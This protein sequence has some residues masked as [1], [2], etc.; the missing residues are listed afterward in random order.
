MMR[1][2]FFSLINHGQDLKLYVCSH[3][4]DE[5]CAESMLTLRMMEKDLLDEKLFKFKPFTMIYNSL[6]MSAAKGLS[7]SESALQITTFSFN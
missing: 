6:A 4:Q 3:T 2:I 1:Q 5:V 7:Q